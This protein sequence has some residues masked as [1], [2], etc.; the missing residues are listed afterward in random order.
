MLIAD[1]IPSDAILEQISDGCTFAEGPAAD[2]EGNVYFSDAP[3]NRIML[4]RVDGD[5]VVWK[6]P[7][8]TANGMNFD[9]LGRLVT[10]CAGGATYPGGSEIYIAI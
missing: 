9:H 7:S 8:Q 10:C 4:Y 1:L 3:N 2:A 5:T 6:Q